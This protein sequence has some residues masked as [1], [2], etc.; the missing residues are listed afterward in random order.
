VGVDGLGDSGLDASAPSDSLNGACAEAPTSAV[1][2]QGG[3]DVLNE[4]RAR[5]V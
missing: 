3:L 5:I 4:M 2:E 1:H